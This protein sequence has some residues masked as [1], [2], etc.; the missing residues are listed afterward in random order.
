MFETKFEN[1]CDKN[2]ALDMTNE[3]NIGKKKYKDSFH[4]RSYAMEG[5]YVGCTGPN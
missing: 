3:I 1:G 2:R 4:G 5:Q